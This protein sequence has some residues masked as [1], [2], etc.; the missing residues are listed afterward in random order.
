GNDVIHTGGNPNGGGEAEFDFIAG[1]D[2]DD[3]FHSEGGREVFYGHDIGDGGEGEVD[4]VTFESIGEGVTASLLEGAGQ[5][6][7]PGHMVEFN[8]I[9][10]LVGT[11]FNDVLTGNDGVNVL[12]G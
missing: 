1:G 9:E 6:V 11:A 4:T 7:R 10:N 8:A 5:V 2:G 12:V 3:T